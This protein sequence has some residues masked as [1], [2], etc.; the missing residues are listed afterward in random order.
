MSLTENNTENLA[1]AKNMSAL[2]Q[3]ITKDANDCLLISTSIEKLVGGWCMFTVHKDHK[4]LSN[5]E[6]EAKL[7]K[8][9]K[10]AILLHGL[11]DDM[12]NGVNGNHT[13]VR[14]MMGQWVTWM[15]G[16]GGQGVNGTIE[17]AADTGW[18][19]PRDADDGEFLTGIK[20]RLKSIE[21]L[22]Q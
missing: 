10:A 11:L 20:D 6:N 21:T 2:I 3:R 19:D 12:Y 22:L 14:G 18:F 17:H 8:Y 4:K 13:T 1:A 16:F 9:H 5:E 7:E 15:N